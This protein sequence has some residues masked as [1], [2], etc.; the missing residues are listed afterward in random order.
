M[1]NGSRIHF[2]RWNMSEYSNNLI[3][4]AT[5]AVILSFLALVETLNAQPLPLERLQGEHFQGDV[6]KGELVQEDWVQ[7]EPGSTP[8]VSKDLSELNTK[9]DIN[10]ATEADWIT[11]KGIGPKRAKA[12]LEYKKQIGG[13]KTVEDLLGVRGIGQKALAKMRPMLKV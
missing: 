9:I 4:W 5:L 13:F 3:R 2:W 12:I 6:T 10:E 1:G 8:S 7:S 11:L